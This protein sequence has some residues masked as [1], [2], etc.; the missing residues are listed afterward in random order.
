M[1]SKSR[2]T[3]KSHTR[4]RS[5]V[6]RHN[7]S[8]VRRHRHSSTSASI[9]S[10]SED[11]L[12]PSRPDV[13][14]SSV[15]KLRHRETHRKRSRSPYNDGKYRR[16]H[17]SRSPS[18]YSSTSSRSDRSPPKHTSRSRISPHRSSRSDLDRKTSRSSSRY[19]GGQ[20]I[21]DSSVSKNRAR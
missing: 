10:Y 6:S 13:R 1:D 20:R 14:K 18:S 2:K 11:S 3:N 8:K 4:S 5:P 9:T 15:C 19:V 7:K 17:R 16:R 21:T 12:S